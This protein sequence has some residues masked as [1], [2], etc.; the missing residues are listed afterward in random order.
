MSL[1]A[2][3]VII[4][5]G[6]VVGTFARGCLRLGHPVFPATRATALAPLVELLPAPEFG[7]RRGAEG[8]PG[9]VL[10]RL[11]PASY[12]RVALLLNDMLPRDFA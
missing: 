8:D 2:P 10:Q 5:L 11:P 6:E 4:G 3:V 7:D 12:Q 9:A 1:K